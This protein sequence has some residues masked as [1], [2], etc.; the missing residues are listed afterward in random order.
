MSANDKLDFER[1]YVLACCN[2]WHLHREDAVAYDVLSELG[3]SRADVRR[4]G[5]TEYDL[6]ALRKI[7]KARGKSNSPFVDGRT[8]RKRKR[9]SDVEAE[10]RS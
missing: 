7:E 10:A 4:M 6:T 9:A 8:I 5:L 1:G 2:L 3:V